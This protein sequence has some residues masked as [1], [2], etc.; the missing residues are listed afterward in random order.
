MYCANINVGVLAMAGELDTIMTQ[1]AERHDLKQLQADGGGRY[2]ILLDGDLEIALLQGGDRIYLEGRLEQVPS[3]ERKAEELLSQYL[4]LN[5][6]QLQDKQ[7]VLSLE[8][9]SDELVL[10][11][12]LPARALSI[13]EFEKALEEFANGLEYWTSGVTAPVRPLAPPP[14]MQMLFP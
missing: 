2:F 4:R 10:F 8:P 9:D 7:E 5:L 1:F 13:A 6:A 14:M 11:R 3:D 12:Q